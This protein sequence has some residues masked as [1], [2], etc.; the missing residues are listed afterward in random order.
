MQ[1]STR[2][3]QVPGSPTLAVTAKVAQMRSQ[4]VDII[5]FGAG[6]PDFATPDYIRDA[7]KRGLDEGWTRYT[8][9]GGLPAV[10]NA[11]I[12]HMQRHFDLQADAK[13][14]MV[15]CG[16][17]HV[18]YN[19]LMCLCDEGDEV[20]LPAPYW[21]TYPVQ[22][23][24]A[25][26]KPVI[27]PSSS[28]NNFRVKVSDLE[29][30]CT[31]RTKGIIINSPNNPTGAA[32]QK[33]DLQAI[34]E[35]AVAHDLWVISDEIYARLTY[36]GYTSQFFA[37]LNV[38][39]QS[40]ADRTLTVY[41]LS[42]TY[43]M[44]GWRIGIAVGPQDLIAAM[45]RLQGQVTSNPAAVSQAGAVA[46]LQQPDDFL[47][48]WLAA[49][50]ERRRAMVER[51]NAMEG[52]TCNEPLGAFYAF[53]NFSGVLGRKAGDTTLAT[54]WD[55]TNYLL[56]KA[57]VAIVPGTPFGAPGFARLSYASS[58]ES[59]TE[60]LNRMEKALQRLS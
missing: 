3:K 45:T 6:E 41:G 55:L 22:I 28:E 52:V 8:P 5:G 17:K 50:D 11:V 27:V 23:E 4:G 2:A 53:P 35:F 34:A 40:M 47:N 29:A 19:A 12:D 16:G 58:M 9:A 21:V 37:T 13:Q 42:K 38:D 59:I 60:G 49:F 57:S 44:T 46:A 32:Y 20:L 1:L 26:G 30:A 48:E 15:S 56:D 36:A 39:G 24:L 33:E 31:P 54:D 25:G 43:A 51:L 10:K 14:V 7:G 18:L